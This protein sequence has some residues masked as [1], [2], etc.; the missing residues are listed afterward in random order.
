AC[1]QHRSGPACI[2]RTPTHHH[3]FLPLGFPSEKPQTLLESSARSRRQPAAWE[4]LR[5]SQVESRALG[6]PPA[7]DPTPHRRARRSHSLLLHIAVESGKRLEFSVASVPRFN[8]TSESRYLD[9]THSSVRSSFMT[10][11]THCLMRSALRRE[12]RLP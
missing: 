5:S 1:N 7:K 11:S 12:P 3:R 10:A 9:Q 2:S 6:R 4:S 8:P